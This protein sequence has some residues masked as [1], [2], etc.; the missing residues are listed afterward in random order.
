MSNVLSEGKKQQVIAL[1]QLGWPLRRIEQ[2][3]GVRRETV[4]AYLKAAGI[5]VR[6]PG[7]WGRRPPAKP[8]NENGVTTGSD[9]ANPANTVNPN[10]KNLSTKG[11]AKARTAK[12]A[13]ENAVTTGFGVDL[14]D[15][16]H[17]SPQPVP[18]TSLCE[19]FRDAVELG[20]SQGRNA[21]AIWQ[22]LRERHSCQNAEFGPMP[23]ERHRH[24]SSSCKPRWRRLFSGAHSSSRDAPL[25][26]V[27]W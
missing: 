13:N 4:G 21:M 25:G 16:E 19:P 22:L 17:E 20:L 6:P 26:I 14:S 18:S 23:S 5:G 3:T 9:A 7:A 24:G 27:S 2:E 15:S 11:K 8:A 1:G 12:P 10:P